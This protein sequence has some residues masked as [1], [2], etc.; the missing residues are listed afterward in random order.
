M[1]D[2]PLGGNITARA[3]Y[4]SS[5]KSQI[6]SRGDSFGLGE[7]GAA[8]CAVHLQVGWCKEVRV[9]VFVSLRAIIIFG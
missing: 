4:D 2:T 7:E 1:V 6:V 5:D 8:G 3:V 9:L